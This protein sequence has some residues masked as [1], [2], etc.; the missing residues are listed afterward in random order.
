MIVMKEGTIYLNFISILSL[1]MPFLYL[2]SDAWED[3]YHR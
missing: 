2:N 1:L 3:E